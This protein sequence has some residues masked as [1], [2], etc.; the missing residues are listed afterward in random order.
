MPDKPESIHQDKAVDGYPSCNWKKEQQNT[1]TFFSTAMEFVKG[2]GGGGLP[3]VK[4][5]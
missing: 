2:G 5:G 3:S 1:D 4:F